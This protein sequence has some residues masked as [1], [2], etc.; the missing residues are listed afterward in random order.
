MTNT[1]LMTFPCDF[2]I[3]VFGVATEQ[4]EGQVREIVKKHFPGIH[5]SAFQTR[6]SKGS[7]YVAMTIT[8]QA[9]SQVQLDNLYRDLSACP[10]ILMTL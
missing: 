9:K 2:P 10:H 1:S 6:S 4:F 3:K 8:V 7:K 5:P